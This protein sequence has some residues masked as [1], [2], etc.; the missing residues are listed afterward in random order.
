MAVTSGVAKGYRVMTPN[1]IKRELYQ[2]E[3]D[4]NFL[5]FSPNLELA[6]FSH[7][8]AGIATGCNP[9]TENHT[10]DKKHEGAHNA[11]WIAP[12]RNFTTGTDSKA[13]ARM[14]HPSA[15]NHIKLK[16]HKGEK[17]LDRYAC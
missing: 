5:T 3:R 13:R 11:C 12:P 10:K 4:N 7:P 1:S 9:S 16:R 8:I 15:E 14:P 6:P 17:F 2:W